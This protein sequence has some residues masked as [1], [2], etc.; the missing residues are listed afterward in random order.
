MENNAIDINVGGTTVSLAKLSEFFDG[1]SSEDL[2][3]MLERARRL[4]TYY[5][6]AI[7]EVETKFRVLN[8]QFALRNEQNPI[9]SIKSRLKSFDSIRGKLL[10]LELPMTLDS[11]ENN[12][13]DIAGVRVICSFIEDIYMLADC[14]LKQDDVKLVCVKDYIKEPKENGYRSLHLIVEIPIFLYDEKRLVKVEIQLRTIA[15]ESWANLEHRLRYKKTLD[16]ATKCV[17][18]AELNECARISNILDCKM[19]MLR[20]LAYRE[21]QIESNAD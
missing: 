10:R 19:Q 6:C 8:E 13:F 7:L 9:E 4:M 2:V 12:I 1:R 15:M 17:M 21:R 5:K 11:I 18:D 3:T 14:I 20:E 16:D